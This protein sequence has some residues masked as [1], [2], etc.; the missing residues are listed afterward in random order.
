LINLYDNKRLENFSVVPR[1]FAG[2]SVCWFYPADDNLHF[3]VKGNEMS[4][5]FFGFKKELFYGL[6]ERAGL[7]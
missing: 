7:N 3:Y 5:D 6:S 1:L 2:K 4:K